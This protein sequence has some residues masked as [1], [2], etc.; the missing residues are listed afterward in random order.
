MA[1]YAQFPARRSDRDDARIFEN[2]R[3]RL[4]VG[5][6]PVGEAVTTCDVSILLSAILE[7]SRSFR[8][9]AT[10]RINSGVVCFDFRFRSA[11]TLDRIVHFLATATYYIMVRLMLYPLFSDVEDLFSPLNVL[12]QLSD[13]M[14]SSVR[15]ADK[16]TKPTTSDRSSS[17]FCLHGSANSGS[18]RKRALNLGEED[19]RSDSPDD[20]KFVV[21]CNVRG[22]KPEEISV[23]AV[24]D[25]IETVTCA[26]SSSGVLAI[27]APKPEP[28]SKKPRTI[29]I[30]VESSKPIA[31][32]ADHKDQA[33]KPEEGTTEAASA[34]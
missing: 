10:A 12:D 16:K 28:P 24:D 3:D 34:S 20:S 7:I 19:T 15:Q 17:C 26:L 14:R 33:E 31:A 9:D 30:A 13:A 1:T 27:E 2:L 21:N 8:C 23:K 5:E 4:E 22:Y 32:P 18:P 11:V 25:C 6:R 29:P